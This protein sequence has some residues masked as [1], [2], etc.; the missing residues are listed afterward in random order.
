MAEA[1]VKK[2]RKSN[3]SVTAQVVMK[4]SMYNALVAEANRRGLSFSSYIKAIIAERPQ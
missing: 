1:N 2:R 4:R 3:D